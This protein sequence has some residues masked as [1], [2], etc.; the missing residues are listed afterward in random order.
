MI[1]SVNNLNAGKYKI[2]YAKAMKDLISHT[3]DDEGK[4]VSI[5]E[6]NFVDG[7]LNVATAFGEDMVQSY[8]ASQI[9]DD[10]DLEFFFTWDPENKEFVQVEE[11]PAEDDTKKYFKVPGIS[12]LNT[13]F[14]NIERLAAIDQRYTV[15]PILNL[16]N[17]EE[18]FNI[19]AN[20]RE[21]KVPEHF[22]KN[23]I[24]VQG[25]EISEILYFKIN[26]YFDAQDLQDPDMKVLIQW[27]T[28]AK[29]ADGNFVE[30]I[31]KAYC[32]DVESYPNYI[33]FGWPISSVIT[34]EA[35]EVSFAVRFYKY[36]DTT[37][38]IEYSL[39]TLTQKVNIKPSLNLDIYSGITNQAGSNLIVD[40]SEGLIIGRLR[41][42]DVNDDSV[43][44]GE[45]Y[46]ILNVNKA[47]SEAGNVELLAANKAHLVTAEDG[48]E[49]I[50]AYLGLDE[51]TG[52]YT[53]PIHIL[54]EANGDGNISYEWKRMKMK[55]DNTYGGAGETLNAVAKTTYMQ[56]EDTK[57]NPE[58][59]YFYQKN[60]EGN[61]VGYLRYAGKLP[62]DDGWSAEDGDL[63]QEEIFE[64]YCDLTINTVGA[65]QA[66]I[67]NRVQNNKNRIQTPVIVVKRPVNPEVEVKELSTL[68]NDDSTY[69][70]NLSKGEEE[71]E[72]SAKLSVDATNSDTSGK[73]VLTYQW[74]KQVFRNGAWTEW[75]SIADATEDSYQIEVENALDF[76]EGYYKAKVFNN[77]NR[78]YD[79]NGNP[80]EG[81]CS[82]SVETPEIL[83]TREAEQLRVEKI[84][85]S[86]INYVGTAIGVNVIV[87]DNELQTPPT[88][89]SHDTYHEVTYK[90]YQHGGGNTNTDEEYALAQE[91]NYKPTEED[92]EA[93]GENDK[94]TYTPSATGVYFCI[95]TNKYNN[96]E[97]T[98][99]TPMALVQ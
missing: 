18:T 7:E 49:I 19:D 85:S 4:Y 54:I 11:K 41:D 58:K 64:R 35:G 23:G 16:E 30:G 72:Y 98:T 1:T 76:E 45:P 57:S 65:Y 48:S 27:K 9:S 69:S 21:I 25:D 28:S 40:E 10:E 34:Q 92:I 44:A 63:P 37:D 13:Y 99:S 43:Q 33:I 66:T 67:T 95:V 24:S 84:W 8:S 20:T 96:S 62:E 51:S 97:A 83:V 2:L 47:R 89:K 6:N 86:S 12:S 77:L 74:F 56:T 46:F 59:I 52:M 17:E 94:S 93:P 70:C 80:Q 87:S 73:G 79:E 71:E 55:E 29:D 36:N 60:T 68:F 26:R 15:L 3:V 38:K 91:G 50:E 61:N 32:V 14:A 88:G 53:R 75:E 81:P 90:W 82:V 22:K 42:S 31:S 39:S 78:L 5:N